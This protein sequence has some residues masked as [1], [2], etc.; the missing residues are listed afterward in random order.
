MFRGFGLG[1]HLLQGGYTG[2]I[3]LG[4]IIGVINGI[5]EILIIAQM[6]I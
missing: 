5:L 1:S 3:L 6:G 4:A 2:D